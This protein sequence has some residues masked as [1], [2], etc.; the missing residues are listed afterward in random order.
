MAKSSK[1]GQT[2]LS[3][4]PACLLI[5]V[6]PSTFWKLVPP[7]GLSHLRIPLPTTDIRPF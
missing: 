1:S 3:A 2:I 7:L 5:A 6:T 4:T